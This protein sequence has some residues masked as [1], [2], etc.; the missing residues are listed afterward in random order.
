LHRP[1]TR[2]LRSKSS[3]WT[4]IRCTDISWEAS[5]EKATAN[6]TAITIV[7]KLNA[8]KIRV[9]DLRTILRAVIDIVII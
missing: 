6:T 8:H 7:S 2:I 9:L 5:T 4:I 3:N 1:D